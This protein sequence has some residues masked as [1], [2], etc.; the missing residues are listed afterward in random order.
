[1]AKIIERKSTNGLLKSIKIFF[2]IAV[3]LLAVGMAYATIREKVNSN[4]M[5]IE[6]NTDDIKMVQGDIKSLNKKTSEDISSIKGDVR[7]ISARQEIVMKGI[8]SIES[9]L[10]RRSP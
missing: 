1:M 8:D 7:E 2:E 9:K 3:A 5:C 10:E 6:N 4:K